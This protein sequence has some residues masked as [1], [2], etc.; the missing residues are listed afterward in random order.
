[1]KERLRKIFLEM[2]NQQLKQDIGCSTRMNL[3]MVEV[4][5]LEDLL[6]IFTGF[7]DESGAYDYN[8]FHDTVCDIVDT[9]HAKFD[10]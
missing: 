7:D 3:Y 5:L 9:I 6:S 8:D 2:L 4:M 10:C 1:M